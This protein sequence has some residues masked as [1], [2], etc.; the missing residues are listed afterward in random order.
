MYILPPS[1][2]GKGG[3]TG[4]LEIFDPDN[5]RQYDSFTCNHCTRVTFV[6]PGADPS[7]L[8]GYCSTCDKLI[9]PE[10]ASKRECNPWEKQFAIMEARDR[11]YQAAKC[12]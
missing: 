9:C 4:H 10:C 7:Q 5:P 11:L 2:R 12:Y 1:Y 6:R 3:Q 8:G